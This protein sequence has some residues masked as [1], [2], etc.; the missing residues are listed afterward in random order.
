MTDPTTPA[1]LLYYASVLEREAKAR[2]GQDVA[3]MLRGAERARQQAA[4]PVQGELFGE[5]GA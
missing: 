1:F 4:V 3:W 5:V 2:P